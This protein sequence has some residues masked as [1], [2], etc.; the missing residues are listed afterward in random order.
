VTGERSHYETL[1]VPP[2]ASAA[3]IRAAYLRL[4]RELHPDTHLDRPDA[5]RRAAER[6]L[7]DVNRAWSVL[8]DDTRRRAYDR[9]RAAP[10]RT[11][12]S[13]SPSGS[14]TGSSS[15]ATGSRPVPPR[16][17]ED[18]D[19]LVD[20]APGGCFG[21]VVLGGF[22]ALLLGIVIVTA[23]AGGDTDE[24][25]PRPTVAPVED[26]QVGECVRYAAAGLTVVPCDGG[27]DAQV[28]EIVTFPAPCPSALVPDDL[29]GTDIR[30]CLLPNQG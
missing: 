15:G 12:S 29:E 9:D 18:D 30:L 13:G 28:A 24:D 19:D 22:V 5:E 25:G 3:D 11:S 23:F 27:H 16:V 1:G 21:G 17:E 7:Q 4:A 8:R 26:V 10:P 2:D 6:R 14:S 20:V